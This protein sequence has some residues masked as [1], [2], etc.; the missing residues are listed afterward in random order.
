VVDGRSVDTTMGFTPLAGLV[1][2]TRSGSVDP[3]LLLWLLQHGG[4]DVETLSGVLEHQSGLKGL[5]GGS[6]DL[7]DLL[8]ARETGDEA[9]GL[10]F[11]V[12]VHRLVREIGGMV[13]SAGGLDVLV[14]TGGI[15]EHAPDVRA[16]T[17]AR[18]GHLGVAVDAGQVAVRADA[19][20]SA[21]G[22]GVR[23]VVVTAAE[24]VEVSR[25]TRELLG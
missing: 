10:A 25:E 20:I 3:G 8:A 11:D 24:D 22:A 16:A 5:A 19:D 4:V 12:F 23:T 21:S 2:Q 6:G 15:G 17:A 14:F 7:R 18:L 13:A 1:M 9:A